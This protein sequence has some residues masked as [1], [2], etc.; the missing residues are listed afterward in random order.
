MNATP[1]V[2]L[3]GETDALQIALKELNE[4]KMPLI[5][6]R[7]LPDGWCVPGDPMTGSSPT[8]QLINLT[9]T[10]IGRVK[11]FSSRPTAT[12]QFLAWRQV[13]MVFQELH[14]RGVQKYTVLF[15]LKIYVSF[16]LHFVS[17]L[18]K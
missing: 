16:M 12:D 4:K 2:D 14:F 7:Y 3:E 10:R 18:A 1:L 17:V 13:R 9:V 11:S 8:K 15:Q 5:V 6:R